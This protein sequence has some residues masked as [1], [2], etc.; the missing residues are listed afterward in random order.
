MVTMPQQNG[1]PDYNRKFEGRQCV[2][3]NE[4][5]GVLQAGEQLG[6]AVACFPVTLAFG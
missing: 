3:I 2:P 4:G 1:G 6:E 5:N